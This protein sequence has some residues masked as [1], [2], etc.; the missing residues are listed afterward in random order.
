MMFFDIRDGWLSRDQHELSFTE[1]GI[2]GTHELHKTK[3]T[4]KAAQVLCLVVIEIAMLLFP[5]VEDI[6]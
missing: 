4:P 2:K 1:I 3:C 5:S 6:E